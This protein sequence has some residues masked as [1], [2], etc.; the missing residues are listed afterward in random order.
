MPITLFFTISMILITIGSIYNFFL[1]KK[2]L[3]KKDKRVFL[4]TSLLKNL[5]FVKSKSME[6]YFHFRVYLLRNVELRYL[7][8]L[9][10]LEF[11]I[12]ILPFLLSTWIPFSLYFIGNN[13]KNTGL[14]RST[15]NTIR[16]HFD[17][18]V[19]YI[20]TFTN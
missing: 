9:Y 16:F 13:L 19:T 1:T 17:T 5:R 15:L 7:K 20:Y 14:D 6:Y 18:L 8:Y 3:E 2:F 11:V 12:Y 10:Y 4:V